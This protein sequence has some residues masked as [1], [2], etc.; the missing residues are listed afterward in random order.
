[1]YGQMNALKVKTHG[2]QTFEKTSLVLGILVVA[3]L[4]VVWSWAVLQVGRWTLESAPEPAR[5]VLRLG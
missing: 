4:A 3:L 5:L 2:E 1:M